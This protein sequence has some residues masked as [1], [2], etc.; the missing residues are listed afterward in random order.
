[1][2]QSI[3]F[4][5]LGASLP[6]IPNTQEF[7]QFLFVR[8]ITA[9]VA[10]A[11]CAYAESLITPSRQR[12]VVVWGG[13]CKF[14]WASVMENANEINKPEIPTHDPSNN[15]VISKAFCHCVW[16]CA[17]FSFLHSHNGQI[18]CGS[19][20][21]LFDEVCSSHQEVK[22]NTDKP[23]KFWIVQ[24]RPKTIQRSSIW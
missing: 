2:W 3:P 12:H 17:I 16:S 6:T 7:R 20:P 24:P 10:T 18:P 23:K 11:S 1:M 9:F 14:K 19:E 8:S 4:R 21:G 22:S 15:F 5:H 13:S